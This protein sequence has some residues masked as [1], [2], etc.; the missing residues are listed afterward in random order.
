MEMQ[1]P[2][3]PEK[4]KM[5]VWLIVVIIAVVV[6]CVIPICLIVLSPVILA[7]LGPAI[8]NVFSNVV[9]SV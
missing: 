1:Q 4:K 6:L 2:P 3:E 9:M 5:P 7:L 8:G